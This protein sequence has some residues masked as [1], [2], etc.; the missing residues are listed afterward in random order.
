MGVMDDLRA[1]QPETRTVEFCMDHE[2]AERL[3]EARVERD[4][5]RRE[6]GRKHVDDR[7]AQEA[8]AKAEDAERAYLGLAA[9]VEGKVIRFVLAAVDPMTFDR[10]KAE[11]RPTEKQ[12]TDARKQNLDPPEWNIDT[13]PPALV[14][15][16]CIEVSGPS[17]KQEGLSVEEAEAIW[18][19][20]NWNSAERAEL[21]NAAMAAYLTR[22]RLDLPPK[23]G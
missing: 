14:A 13:F 8:E 5:A 10:L 15:A 3:S 11:H 20:P 1:K 2:L 4:R 16:A 12:R 18:S 9:E 19:A 7:A 23:V 21:G 6:A 17:G 22:T